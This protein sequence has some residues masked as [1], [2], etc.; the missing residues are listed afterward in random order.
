[1]PPRTSAILRVFLLVSGWLIV[2]VPTLSAQVTEPTAQ[3]RWKDL[4]DSLRLSE[5]VETTLEIEAT[6]PFEVK[7][8]V[9]NL[10]DQD[11][12]PFW[13][14]R[15]RGPVQSEMTRRDSTSSYVWSQ[16]IRLQPRVAGRE[17][18]LSLR[19]L[20]LRFLPEA[21]RPVAVEVALEVPPRA[22]RVDAAPAE[23]PLKTDPYPPPQAAARPPQAILWLGIVGSLL[24]GTLL[25][26]RL[27][28]PAQ[29]P[30]VMGLQPELSPADYINPIYPAATFAVALRAWLYVRLGGLPASY[31]TPEA[32]QAGAAM[33]GIVNQA[34]DSIPREVIRS[35]LERC[36]AAQYGAEDLSESERQTLWDL[37]Q[38]RPDA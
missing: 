22:L 24:G 9:W 31:S 7:G 1:M 28:R 4:P 5:S 30:P 25:L 12:T 23:G 11:P 20:L 3:V 2:V 32:I 38:N 35:I 36:D 21:T 8:E 14:I 26:V 17:V 34:G 37:A 27:V 10:V 33:E 16:T 29:T 6:A 13:E 15:S 18:R 19:P